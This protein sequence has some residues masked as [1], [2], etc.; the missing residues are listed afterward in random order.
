MAYRQITMPDSELSMKGLDVC[1]RIE[2]TSGI[3][4]YYYLRRHYGRS[5]KAERNR[6]C[7]GCGGQWLLNECWLERYDFRCDRCR[8]VSETACDVQ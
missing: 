8:L 2:K 4:T 6:K 7:P 1:R 5:Q 3:P